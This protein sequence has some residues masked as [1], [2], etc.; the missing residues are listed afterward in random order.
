MK[1]LR[2]APLRRVWGLA[3]LLGALSLAQAAC[4]ETRALVL[5]DTSGAWGRWGEIYA[6]FTANLA[7]RFGGYDAEP[8]GAYRPGQI[9]AHTATIYIGSSY[10]EVLPKTFLA[11]AEATHK[12]LMWMG[13]GVEAMVGTPAHPGRY[14]WT[15]QSEDMADPVSAVAYKGARFTRRTDGNGGLII[16]T[17]RRPGEVQVLAT[18]HRVDGR[19]APWAIRSGNL[20]FIGENPFPYMTETDRYLVFADL[21]FDLLAP[22]TPV[23]HRAMARIEDVGPNSDPGEL[24]AVADYMSSE[25]VPYTVGVYDT[26]RDPLHR[27]DGPRTLTLAQAP[28]LVAALKYMQAHGATLIMHGHTHQYQARP[29][30]YSAVSA[31]DFEFFTSHLSKAGFV[32]YDGPAPED[33]EAWARGRLDAAFAGWAAAGLSKPTMFEFPHYAASAADYRV[34]AELFKARY[35]RSQ[36]YGGVIA[37]RPADPKTSEGQF[38][39]YPV[40]DIYGQWVL[41]ENLGNHEPIGYNHHPPRLPRDILDEARRNLVMHDGFASFYHHP[42]LNIAMLKETVRGLKAEGYVFVSP[43]SVLADP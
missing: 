3:A 8:V 16:P 38:F 1:R 31:D 28:A 35:E 42:F 6:T 19:T 18:A 37:G 21:M 2:H 32:I 11:D 10:G 9:E 39:P 25:H 15:P 12:P 36:Y 29:N 20:Y 5:Y 7:G 13:Y 24:R 30:P 17:I 4:A 14:G 41:P 34:A 22:D 27:Q 26:Y 40:R 43:D 33:S 23:R